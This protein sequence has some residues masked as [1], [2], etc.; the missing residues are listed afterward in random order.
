M[1]VFATKVCI[2]PYYGPNLT[3]YYGI[4]IMICETAPDSC[5]FL[6]RDVI[7]ENGAKV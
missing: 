3:L 2:E 6:A 4:T 1:P 5:P 7:A